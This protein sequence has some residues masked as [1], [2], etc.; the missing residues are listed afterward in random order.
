MTILKWKNP[1]VEGH[2][3]QN[4][5]VFNSPISGLFDTVLGDTL[6]T[7]EFASFVPA[8]NFSENKE[9]YF[10]DLSTPGFEKKDFKIEYNKGALIIT[11]N[12]TSEKEVS[13]KR[14]SHKEFNFG[15]FKRTFTLPEAIND[16][17]VNATYENGILHISIAKS[18]QVKDDVREINIS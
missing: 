1:S 3:T 18:E 14:Y 7:R 4:P 10:I 8:V 15:S 13:E 11:G 5:A 12:H 17:D 16:Q 9:Y 2:R 6:F